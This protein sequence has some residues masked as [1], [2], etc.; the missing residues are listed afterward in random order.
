MHHFYSFNRFKSFDLLTAGYLF[1]W[2]ILIRC[3]YNSIPFAS[4]LLLFHFITVIIVLFMAGL[5][6]ILPFLKFFRRWYLFAFL[7]LFFTALHYLI[8]H[9]HPGN[10][11]STLIKIDQFLT[12]T[13]PTVWF[14]K[15][16][17][18]W[19]TELLQLSYLTFYFLPLLILIPLYVQKDFKRY[20]HFAFI[21]LLSFYLSYFGYLLFPALG[22]RYFLTH[23]HQQSLNGIG[24]YEK[25]SHTLNGL[26]NIQWD[27]FPSAHVAIALLVSHFTLRYFPKI[28]MLTL[29]LVVFLIISTIYL[30]YH[31]LIDVLAGIVLYLLVLVIDKLF[32]HHPTLK[33]N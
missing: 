25:I 11:D 4:S 2:I 13:N 24:W 27:A 28:F 16:Y 8:P 1:I 19:I 14:E 17:H 20:D 33:N 32:Y 12:G 6:P 10:I 30:R 29:P 26:E 5:S 23:L 15:F 18:P 3:Y 7:P 31:Y 21:V 9:V 22:P